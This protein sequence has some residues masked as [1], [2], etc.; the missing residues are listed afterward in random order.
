MKTESMKSDEVK[1]ILHKTV[2]HFFP[3]LGTWINEMNDPRN[4]NST[5]YPLE[6]MLWQGLLLFLLKLG[7]RR[8]LNVV[9][10]TEEALSNLGVLCGRDVDTAAHDS[11]LGYLA[12]RLGPDQLGR[13]RHRM[14][15]GLLRKKCLAR[16]RVLGHYLVVLD[17][18]WYVSFNKPHCEHCLRM[19]VSTRDRENG[20]KTGRKRK[21]STKS[22]KTVVYYHAV[23]E[24]KLVTANGMALSLG[25][26]FLENPG[27]DVDVQDCEL[28]AA[29]RLMKRLKND[30]PRLAICLGLD[31]LYA[32][33]TVF[34]LCKE[35]RWKYVIT[36]KQGSMPETW[37]EYVSLQQLQKDNT[38]EWT[39]GEVRQ[40]YRW[41]TDIGFR[42]P[43]FNVLQCDEYKPG[44]DRE[45][46]HTPF[47]WVT[48]FDIGRHNYRAVAR[49]GRLRWKIENEGFNMQK[50]GGYNLQHPYGMHPVALQNYYLVLQ[51]A[52]L[53]SQLMEKGD[54]L[55]T[56]VKR[57][58]G[59]LRNFALLLLISLRTTTF[60]REELAALES[61]RIQIRLR[62][63]D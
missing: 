38:G 27:R 63:P 4:E 10:D 15:R 59:S 32:N 18:T 25:T 60:D 40:Q 28:R 44:K 36:F 11:T 35:H 5:T 22:K 29:Y 62:G 17:G 2:R 42:G 9:F 46:K 20:G 39:D 23:V 53:I 7:A 12:E 37:N 45:D 57:L 51:I 34:D 58:C 26:E 21:K 52:H 24:A 50:T 19:R 47:V 55:R 41:V 3:E 31:A 1:K 48:N 43:C 14:M 13:L 8:Q 33:E 54:L 49:A 56:D 61:A 16:Y 30:F 6:Q